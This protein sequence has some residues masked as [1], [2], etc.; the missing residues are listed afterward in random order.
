MRRLLR[1]RRLA[2]QCLLLPI[3]VR[4]FRTNRESTS[5][6]VRKH[7]LTPK[8]TR[9]APTPLVQCMLAPI[10]DTSPAHAVISSDH[11]TATS[12]KKTG[13]CLHDQQHCFQYLDTHFSNRLYRVSYTRNGLEP[14]TRACKTGVRHARNG[15]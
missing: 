1:T 13:R 8:I 10:R 6:A 3:P 5:A 9:Y 15:L 4:A 2:R 11:C 12:M 14:R 7:T